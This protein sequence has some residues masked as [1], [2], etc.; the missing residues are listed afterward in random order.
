MTTAS[1]KYEEL[2]E[3]TFNILKDP[4]STQK[5][6]QNAMKKLEEAYFKLSPTD[7]E[8]IKPMNPEK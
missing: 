5:Q 2:R 3:E 1:K 8:A 6:K 4:S 7:I